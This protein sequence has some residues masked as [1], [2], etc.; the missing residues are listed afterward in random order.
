MKYLL[1]MV[2]LNGDSTSVMYGCGPDSSMDRKGGSR[3]VYKPENQ[4]K[5]M[6]LLLLMG[7]GEERGVAAVI[8]GSK[9][10]C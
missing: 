2:V 4:L 10:C 1:A 8:N 7:D 3:Q 9:W 5:Y 6:Q